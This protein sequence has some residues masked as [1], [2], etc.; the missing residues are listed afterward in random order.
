MSTSLNGR[1]TVDRY[2]VKEIDSKF[3]EAGGIGLQA[4]AP[5]KEV[6]FRDIRVKSCRSEPRRPLANFMS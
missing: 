2:P 4:H 3:P 5:W 1:T 6:R